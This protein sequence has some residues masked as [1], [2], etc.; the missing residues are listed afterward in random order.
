MNTVHTLQEYV[1]ALRAAGI[2]TD[3][4]V[5]E[6][7][8]GRGVECLTYDTRTLRENALF[9]CKGAH[10]KEE[11]LRDALNALGI[12]DVALRAD[13]LGA[14]EYVPAWALDCIDIR[15]RVVELPGGIGELGPRL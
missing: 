8:L 3:C 15:L 14:V 2:L 6:A 1:D 4:T 12:A 5:S 13:V 11:Y 10:F 7:L 9:I